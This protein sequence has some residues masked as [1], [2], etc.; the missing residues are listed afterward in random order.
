[1]GNWISDFCLNCKDDSGA[2]SCFLYVGDYFSIF[3]TIG[4]WIFPWGLWVDN[5]SF[6]FTPK[7]QNT[8]A[9]NA[10]I[11]VSIPLFKTKSSGKTIVHFPKLKIHLTLHLQVLQHTWKIFRIFK[12]LIRV[13]SHVVQPINAWYYSCMQFWSFDLLWRHFQSS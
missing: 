1:M 6:F 2:V 8:K 10:L 9:P 13:W 11:Y 5:M 3:S 4:E 12:T 7:S